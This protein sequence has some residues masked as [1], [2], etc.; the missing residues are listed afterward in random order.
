[1]KHKYLID[2]IFSL[3]DMYAYRI[4]TTFHFITLHKNSR[5]QINFLEIHLLFQLRCLIKLKLS[6]SKAV[7]PEFYFLEGD[8]GEKNILFN[9]LSGC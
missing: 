6:R 4:R 7:L 1:M 5:K 9:V 8:V 3:V 2:K